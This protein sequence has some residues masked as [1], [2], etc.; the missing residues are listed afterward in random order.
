MTSYEE[1]SGSNLSADQLVWCNKQLNIITNVKI[2]GPKDESGL[3]CSA[4]RLLHIIFK[5]EIV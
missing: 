4:G 5:S 2:D 3:N 1:E